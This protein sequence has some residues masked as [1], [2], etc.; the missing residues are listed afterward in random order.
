M[1]L[2]KSYQLFTLGLCLVTCISCK[3]TD[4]QSP[5]S[6][7]I[8]PTVSSLAKVALVPA[9]G[10][11]LGHFYGS[12]T[13]SETDARIGKHPQI[14]LS[15]YG[16]SDHWA[17]DE[18]TTQDFTDGRIPLI[19]WEPF[20]IKFADI[21][22]G[23]YDKQISLQADEAK[24]LGKRFF[25]DF[26]AEMNEEEGWGGHNPDLYIKAY[27][28]I[29]DI[30]VSR[31]ATNAVWVWCPNNVDSPDAPT[32]M[33]Y[34]PGDT[35]VD[36]VGADGYNWGTSDSDH[37]WETFY[38]VFKDIYTK[39]A[40]TGK[41]VIIGEMASDEVGGDKA[42]WISEIIPTLKNQFPAIKAVVWFDVDKE[43]H[44]QIN[45]TQKSLDAYR[46]MAKDP[47]FNIH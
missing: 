27:R 26:A 25:L 15:Y 4:A 33:Q 1:N 12:G 3:K 24:G 39:I 9:K 37:E 21:I 47:Y 2:S 5:S 28:H 7:S 19:N 17:K 42:K 10:A 8:K 31:G 41:P 36:W 11:L 34:Y 16:W 23:K 32:A 20:D 38:N 14:H 45:S 43:R 13:I 46:N 18:A 44:W 30:F 29:H 40:A 22:N 35:Y 6:D